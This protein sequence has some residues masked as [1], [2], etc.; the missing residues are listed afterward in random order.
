MY[1]E[2]KDRNRESWKFTYKGTDLV[3]AAQA[4]VDFYAA[5]EEEYRTKMANALNDRSVAVNS[6]KIDK[7]KSRLEFAAAQRENCE[8][9]LHEFDR[10]PDREFSLSMADVV[11]F[12][13]AGHN[14]K[15][16]DDD[17]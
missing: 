7:L 10:T 8:V 11:F 2:F 3:D 4:K 1:T 13:L 15:T 17:E 14:I 5:Q 16:N 9:F 12:G 6:S